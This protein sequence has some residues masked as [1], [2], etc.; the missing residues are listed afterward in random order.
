MGLRWLRRR[1]R[2]VRCEACE[3]WRGVCLVLISPFA[4]GV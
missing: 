3:V 4:G 2:G 1:G